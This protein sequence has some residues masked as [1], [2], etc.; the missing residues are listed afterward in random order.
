MESLDR[1][2][3]ALRIEH[4]ETDGARL[5]TARPNAVAAGLFRIVWDECLQLG[6][7]PLVLGMGFACSQKDAG[8]FRPAVRYDHVDH[9]DALDWRPG[10]FN[11]EETWRF[12]RFDAAPEFL[13]GGE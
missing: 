2:M 5:R 11:P 7:G 1:C 3:G 9:S 4:I 12:T 13:L 8:E 6:L 10:R